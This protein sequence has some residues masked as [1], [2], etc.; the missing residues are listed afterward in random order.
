M[1]STYPSGSITFWFY[2]TLFVNSLVLVMC[3]KLSPSHILSYNFADFFGRNGNTKKF[4]INFHSHGLRSISLGSPKNS[5][6]Y[7]LRAFGVGLSGDPSCTKTTFVFLLGGV[8]F[9][10][11]ISHCLLDFFLNTIMENQER[12]HDSI[13]F[14]TIDIKIGS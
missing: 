13:V 1:T 8:K 14:V 7:F 12:R 2:L 10:F 3:G 4:N 6:R 5:L 11:M 9:G